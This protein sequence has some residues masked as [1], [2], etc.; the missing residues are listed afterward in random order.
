[1]AKSKV[2][3]AMDNTIY[4][5]L[6]STEKVKKEKHELQRMFPKSITQDNVD[7]TFLIRQEQK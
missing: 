6:Q 4:N 5:L 2:I 3:T 7:R 1:M